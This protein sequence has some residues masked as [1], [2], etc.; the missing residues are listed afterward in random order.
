MLRTYRRG[1]RRWVGGACEV[2]EKY[3]PRRARTVRSQRAAVG[4]RR[5][6]AAH[7]GRRRQGVRSSPRDRHRQAD[8]ARRVRLRRQDR[9]AHRPRS[10]R[11]GGGRRRRRRR[12]PAGRG[13]TQLRRVRR[14]SRRVDRHPAGRGR[15]A[16]SGRRPAGGQ[17]VQSVVT[18][19]IRHAARRK[20]E[21]AGF[22]HRLDLERGGYGSDHHDRT[23]LVRI[24]LSRLAA[25]DDVGEIDPST[26][27]II[28]DTP[29]DAAC[30]R[31]A[32]VRCLLVATG[33]YSVD[34]LSDL[35]ADHVL[36]DLADVEGV[37]HIL[38]S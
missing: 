8:G 7:A 36:A 1:L 26:V 3:R 24:A 10:A 37:L 28:G 29:R 16:R 34:A 31:G 22:D 21:A 35:G 30:A 38:S 17:A 14:R 18:G 6:P 25:R 5:H 13:G 32:G 15:P 19:N 33:T 12:P 23:E 20:L 2:G 27:W 11:G 9:P 4:H